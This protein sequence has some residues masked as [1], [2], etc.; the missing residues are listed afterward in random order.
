MN[1]IDNSIFGILTMTGNYEERLVDNTK[2]G[3]FE[4]DTVYVT[5]RAW[6]YETAVRH[7]KF[8]D[9]NWIVVEG[10][11]DIEKAYD[12]HKKWVTI[13]EN[14]PNKIHDCYID[15]DFKEQQ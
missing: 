6:D 5:D 7:K 3:D 15:V 1:I 13:M 14:N 4:V 11:N 10:V 2:R 9:N 8:N 12:I